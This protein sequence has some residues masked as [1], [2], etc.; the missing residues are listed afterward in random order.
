MRN[1]AFPDA[2]HPL[3]FGLGWLTPAGRQHCYEGP[4]SSATGYKSVR[5]HEEG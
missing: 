3:V 1:V 2:S 5:P 4:N